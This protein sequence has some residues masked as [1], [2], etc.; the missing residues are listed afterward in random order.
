MGKSIMETAP[1][2]DLKLNMDET[3]FLMEAAS[4]FSNPGKMAK[5]LA[6]AG[7]PA[8]ALHARL[9]EPVRNAI[10]RASE[11]AIRKAM[12]AAIRTLP[13]SDGTESLNTA[14]NVSLILPGESIRSSRLHRTLTSIS[15]AAGGF[16]GLPALPLELPVTTVLILRAI[17]D[18]ARL[19]GHDIR[20][21]ETQLECLMVFTMTNLAT[22]APVARYYL[23]R[24]SLV[25]VLREAATVGGAIATKDLI[26]GVELGTLPIFTKLI[27]GISEKFQIRVSQKFVAESL[28][29][30]GAVG[31]GALNYAF[32]DYFVTAARFHFGV[33]ALEKKHGHLQIQDRLLELSH[34][35]NS[36][37]Q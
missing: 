7:R 29:F 35:R 25:G 36:T 37:H 34:E 33:R 14:L 21:I 15:G 10:A 23:A 5:L 9:P 2:K 26:R 31:G 1:N 19:F 8:E 30:V 32:T 13:K 22:D 3:A 18:Q 6:W 4:F 12:I 17:T 28:P 20:S 27:S 24:A 16:F 11:I